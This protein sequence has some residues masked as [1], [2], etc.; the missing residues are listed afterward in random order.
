MRLTLMLSCEVFPGTMLRTNVLIHTNT[1]SWT[2][3]PTAD[4]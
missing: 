3:Q 2:D 4:R 1:Y